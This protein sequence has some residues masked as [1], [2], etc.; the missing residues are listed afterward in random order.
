MKA[1]LHFYIV[2]ISIFLARSQDS[3]KYLSLISTEEEYA[4]LKGN[5]N[6][7]KF[8]EVDAIKDNCNDSRSLGLGIENH[9]AKSFFQKTLSYLKKN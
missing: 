5:P 4:L 3:I 8:G 7:S 6:T 9:D 2:F 1:L